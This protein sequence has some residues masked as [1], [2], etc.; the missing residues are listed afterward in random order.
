MRNFSNSLRACSSAWALEMW[1]ALSRTWR[2]SRLRKVSR[3]LTQV[4]HGHGDLSAGAG[5]SQVEE[6]FDQA[7]E[8][9]EFIVGEVVLADGD[10]A[11]QDLAV[12][13]ACPGGQAHMGLVGGPREAMSSAAVWP[14]TA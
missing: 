9:F 6:G 12:G 10:V 13:A 5:L 7:A 11:W 1:P 8:V 2:S 3:R 14:W 4:L